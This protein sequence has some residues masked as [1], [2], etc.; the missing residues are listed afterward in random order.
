MSAAGAQNIEEVVDLLSQSVRLS[1][2]RANLPDDRSHRW[3]NS[4]T[5]RYRAKLEQGTGD[6]SAD[7][8]LRIAEGV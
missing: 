6:G 1:M 2:P 5:A 3:T 4:D 8:S 7:P